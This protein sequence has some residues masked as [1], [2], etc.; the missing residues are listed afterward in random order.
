MVETGTTA[1]IISGLEHIEEEQ[2]NEN[3]F[4]QSLGTQGRES[5]SIV[6]SDLAHMAKAKGEESGERTIR[7]GRQYKRDL[8]ILNSESSQR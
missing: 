7:S 3:S 8:E 5:A 1:V 6:E 2:E 4:I